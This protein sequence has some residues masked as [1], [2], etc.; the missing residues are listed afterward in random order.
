MTWHHLVA[1]GEAADLAGP[2][3]AD[4]ARAC[5]RRVLPALGTARPP[6]TL[7]GAPGHL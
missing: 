2:S 6:A 4:K 1:G 5:S 3:A 7:A